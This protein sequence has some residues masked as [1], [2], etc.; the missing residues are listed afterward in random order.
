MGSVTELLQAANRGDADAS[1]QLFA[2]LYKDLKRLAHA[3]LRSVSHGELNTTALVH[4]SFLKLAERGAIAQIDKPAFFTYIGKVMRSVVMDVVRERRTLKRG[5][6]AEPVTLTTG[7]AAESMNDEQLVAINDAL[8][9]LEK[10]SPELHALVEM[11]YFAGLSIPEISE[12][13]GRSVR[14]IE[15]DWEKARAFLRQFIES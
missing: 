3:R 12:I 14:T 6:S 1:R 9:A 13:T 2:L 11:R 4:E 7:V 10:L 8:A 5:G 15:R